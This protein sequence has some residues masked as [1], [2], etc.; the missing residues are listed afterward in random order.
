[1]VLEE[2]Q[3]LRLVRAFAKVKDRKKRQDFVEQIEAMAEKEQQ[4]EFKP[5][6]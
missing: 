3:L 2:L 5:A 1:M 4:P 6:S